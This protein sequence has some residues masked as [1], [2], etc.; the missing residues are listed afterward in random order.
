MEMQKP[1]V[2]VVGGGISGLATANRIVEESHRLDKPVELLLLE[3]GNRLGG[4]IHTIHRDGFVLEGGPDS[5]ITEKP[6]GLQLCRRLGL[7]SDLIGTCEADRRSFVVRKDRLEPVPDGFYLLAPTRVWPVVTTS[8]F[9]WPGKMRMAADLVLPRKKRTSPDH[10]ESLASFVRRRLGREA[11]DRMAQPMVGGI[12]TADPETL[13]L[14]AT[15]PRFLDMEQEHRSLILAM[16]RQRRRTLAAASTPAA[17][18][19]YGLFASLS[20][21]MEFLVRAIEQR[22]PQRC[23]RLGTEVHSVQRNGG[24]KWVLRLA[25]GSHLEADAVCLALA[26]HQSADLIEECDGPL[27]AKLRSIAYASTAT[28]NLAFRSED[29]SRELDGFGFVVP[30]CENRQLLACTFSHRKFSGRAPDGFILLRG[31][32]GGA[33]QPGALKHTDSEIVD[34]VCRNLRDLLGLEKRPT[35]TLVERHSQAMAQYRVG[36]LSLVR[37][38]ENRLQPHAT[39]QLAGN[40]FT[41]IGIPDCIRRGEECA[42][43][44]LQAMSARLLRPAGS[45]AL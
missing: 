44:L 19:R 27:A 40:G 2:V 20:Q 11:L 31:F 12:Y 18:P 6:W 5:F 16:L 37:E 41:G 3:A 26:A 33:L 35:F 4:V 45:M 22:L 32:I 36:H 43:R 34:I 25:D 14:R 1:R 17:G 10:D 28:V 9:S 38:I 15:M 23:I 42:D 39:L 13:S 21:G 29:V 24:K 7:E 30:A 8:I